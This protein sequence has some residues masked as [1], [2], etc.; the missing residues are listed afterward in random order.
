MSE[1]RPITDEHR[2]AARTFAD[3]QVDRLR[4]AIGFVTVRQHE[5]PQPAHALHEVTGLRLRSAGYVSLAHQTIGVYTNL[6]CDEFLARY[7]FETPMVSTITWRHMP[8]QLRLLISSSDMLP[9]AWSDPHH[10]P[11][12][13]FLDNRVRLTAVTPVLRFLTA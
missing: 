5:V 7:R 1:T 4:V 12:E 13:G 10:P 8:A 3:S 6:I 2:E 9:M 11:A